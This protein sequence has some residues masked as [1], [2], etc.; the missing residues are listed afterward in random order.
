[1]GRG[2]FQDLRSLFIDDY[3]DA[4]RETSGVPVVFLDPDEFN[5]RH[6]E[7][8]GSVHPDDINKMR[9]MLERQ[10]P[11]IT[12]GVTN[13]D[14]EAAVEQ[15]LTRGPFALRGELV[16][17]AGSSAPPAPIC[18]VNEPGSQLNHKNELMPLLSAQDLSRIREI[19]GWDDHWDRIIGIHEG[20]H[21]N[22]TPLNPAG[23][24]PDQL[25]VAILQREAEAD[26]ASINWA[27][28]NGL[29]DIAQ[30][31][32]DFRALG[33]AN[34]PEH[35][36]AILIDR[37]GPATQDHLDAARTFRAEM[38]S[39]V[40]TDQGISTADAR[41]MLD[42]RPEEFN[43]HIKR[44]LQNGAFDGHPN[45]HVKESVEAFSGAVQRQITDRRIERELEQQRR[46]E[47]HD[48]H[49]ALDESRPVLHAVAPEEAPTVRA[50][51]GP[52]DTAP[53][54]TAGAEIPA[55]DAPAQVA[56]VSTPSVHADMDVST[57]R[58]GAAVV[59][60]ADG[61]QASMKIGGVSASAFFASHADND[62]AMQRIALEQNAVPSLERQF[63]NT[64]PSVS[65]SAYG[66]A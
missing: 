2:F 44:L 61:D 11:G 50:E 57:I 40:A 1:M 56:A 38:I 25:G 35:A 65:A 48:R 27:R 36:S 52:V 21:C 15:S 64:G 63:Q 22:Q 55:E 53:V 47:G 7:S 13:S 60:L 58:G 28:Q 3:K 8:T 51:A 31:M 54:E 45:P 23:M 18:I 20:T 19:P 24:T 66:V 42:D 39:K 43:G 62:L 32:I 12:N 14:L 6:Y 10:L 26:Q 16:P 30:A 49:G 37:P 4:V 46:F 5:R 59:A 33:A 41:R 9:E 34:D 29:N 17:P